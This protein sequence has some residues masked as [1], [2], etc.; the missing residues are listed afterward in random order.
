M[1]NIFNQPGDC[2]FVSRK[3]FILYLPLFGCL[4]PFSASTEQVVSGQVIHMSETEYEFQISPGNG[5]SDST[6]KKPQIVVRLSKR[7]F[8]ERGGDVRELEHL[9]QRLSTLVRG[10]VIRRDDLPAEIL[11]KRPDSGLLE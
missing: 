3:I 2:L 11:E 4:F 7:Y 8:Q 1:K 6:Q 10:N 5:M 9:I